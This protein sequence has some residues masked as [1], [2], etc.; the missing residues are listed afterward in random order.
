MR[1]DARDVIEHN[2]RTESP[3]PTVY[4]RVTVTTDVTALKNTGGKCR[5]SSRVAAV[6]ER[7]PS[8]PA[9][10]RALRM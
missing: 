2:D 10:R 4:D 7:Q 3:K 1:E 9:A 5:M 6:S 8:R